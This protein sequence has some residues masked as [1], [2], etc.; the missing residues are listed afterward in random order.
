[1]GREMPF[2][3]EH[4]NQSLSCISF[5][6]STRFMLRTAH[7]FPHMVQLSSCSGGEL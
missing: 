6:A 7:I 5:P 1:M 3:D 2:M 4:P